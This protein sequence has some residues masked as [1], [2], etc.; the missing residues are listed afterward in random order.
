MTL[1][2]T[3]QEVKQRL[4]YSEALQW[5][6]YRQ[7]Y[8][9]IGESRTAYLLAAIATMT[10]RAAGGKATLSDF[11]P[12]AVSDDPKSIDDFCNF[13]MSG[14]YEREKPRHPDA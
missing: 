5:F 7:K 10:N 8:G 2:G 4:A 9:G 14:P 11:L 3:V 12:G 13:L 6:A 1:G